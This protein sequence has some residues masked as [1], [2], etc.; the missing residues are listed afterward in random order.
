VVAVQYT[1]TLDFLFAKSDMSRV[2]PSRRR[3]LALRKEN[4]FEVGAYTY[5]LKLRS[6]EN[7]LGSFDIPDSITRDKKLRLRYYPGRE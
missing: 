3:T 5:Q 6:G 7:K 2:P 4:P 1:A